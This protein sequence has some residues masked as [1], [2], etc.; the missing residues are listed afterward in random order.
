MLYHKDYLLQ[1]YSAG[2]VTD[3]SHSACLKYSI[4]YSYNATCFEWLLRDSLSAT[5]AICISDTNN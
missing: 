4:K 5:L 1:I 3:E 2:Q